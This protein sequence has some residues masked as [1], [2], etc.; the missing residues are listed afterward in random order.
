MGAFLSGVTAIFSRLVDHSIEISALICL[1]FLVKWIAAKKLPSWWHYSLWLMLLVRMLVPIEFENRLNVFNF[2]PDIREHQ[3]FEMIT[4]SP[5]DNEISAA[6][7]TLPSP[8]DRPLLRVLLKKSVPMLWFAGAIVFG[9]C[10]L[11]KSMSFWRSVRRLS[12]VT[13]PKVLHLLAQ[14]K[15]RMKIDGLPV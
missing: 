6:E 12:P 1:I 5:S 15:K 3:V 14:C 8:Q 4:D 7:I 11:F 2:I 13:D 9:I 10:I